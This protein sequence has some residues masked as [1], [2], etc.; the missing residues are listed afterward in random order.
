MEGSQDNKL[1]DLLFTKEDAD[2]LSKQINLNEYVMKLGAY[3]IDAL[4]KETVKLRE[5]KASI[6]EHTQELAVHNYK[7]FIETADCSRALFKQFNAIENNLDNLLQN[8]PKFEEK[9]QAFAT[10]TG[11]INN[12]RKLNTLTLT[13]N[14]QLLEILELPQLMDSFIKDGL[15]EDS[16]ELAAY[17]RTKLYGRHSDIP[18]FKSIADDIEKSWLVMLHKLLGELRSEITMPKCLQVVGHLRRMDVFAESELRLKFLQARDTWL[19]HSLAA[20]ATDDIN[21]HL[22]KTIEVTRVN[23]FNVITQ[24]RAVFNDDEHSPLADIKSKH[25]NHNFIFFSWIR[26][27]IDE[28]LQVLRHDLSIIFGISGDPMNSVTSNNAASLDS[29]L[30]QCMYFGLSFSKVGCDFRPVL[31]PIFTEAIVATFRNTVDIATNDFHQNMDR[32]TLLNRNHPNV[33]WTK[34]KNTEDSIQPPDSLLEFYPLAEYLNHILTGFNALR[35]CPALAVVQD[36]IFILQSSLVLVSKGL[37]QL[38]SLEQQAFTPNARDA[39]TRL[40]LCYSDDLLPYI[41]R[42]I[43]LI[44]PTNVLS[45]HLGIS[46][47]QLHTEK[48]SYL[49]RTI[50]IAPITHLLPITNYSKN[51]MPDKEANMVSSK[52]DEDTSNQVEEEIGESLDSENTDV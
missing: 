4:N 34:S 48:I 10:E 46:V 29:I 51:I 45:V 40:C 36:I 20:I 43:H 28:F 11:G 7:T 32:F 18:I 24:Y 47:Q 6:I 12:L 16:L 31:V 41:Q 30:G 38:Y 26:N 13:R 1:L 15:Y 17:V 33:R 22:S 8:V 21:Y 35:L 9:C 44:Y 27:K 50:V 52:T 39:F 3:K 2:E 5:E 42:C 14:A 19:Q 37:V 49:D 23:L 25:V